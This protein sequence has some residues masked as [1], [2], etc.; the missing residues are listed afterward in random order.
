MQFEKVQQKKKK[1][2]IAK[3]KK[4]KKIK[5]KKKSATEQTTKKSPDI[6]A[7]TTDKQEC[8]KKFLRFF[9]YLN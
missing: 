4:K 9:H 1:K 7:L 5:K 2:K 6:W 8:I 3:K